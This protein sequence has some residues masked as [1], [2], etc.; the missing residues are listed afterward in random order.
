MSDLPAL[1]ESIEETEEEK[2]KISYLPSPFVAASLP[3]RDVKAPNFK[4]KFN[5]LE[6]YLTGSPKVP[7]GKY[8]RL[9]LSLLT[10]KAVI[11]PKVDEISFHYDTLSHLT[12]ELLLPRQR[13][14]DIREQ[15]VLFSLSSFQ[16]RE[17]KKQRI[18]KSLFDEYKDD[19]GFFTAVWN[20]HGNISF[21]KNL[22]WVD[23]EDEKTGKVQNT[24]GFTVTLSKEFVELC[25]NHSVPIDYTVYS[26]I[27][28]PLGKDLYAWIIYRNNILA[29]D[30][31]LF[32]PRKAIVAQFGT[33]GCE[34]DSKSE[35][36]TYISIVDKLTEIKN[37]YYPDLKIT[38]ES[39]NMGFTLR[40]SKTIIA[41][42][43][44]RYVLV[45]NF[46]SF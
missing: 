34:M 20:S 44:K 11:S 12:D 22:Q 19:D 33:G 28:S 37:K 29:E 2:H 40:K 18:Q 6:L 36:Q 35:S 39:S 3:L 38:F 9:V 1:F 46:I 25:K 31:E 32:V 13:G 27:S 26:Q 45:T 24:I 30:E 15:L 43:D 23:L 16:Y 17:K 8:A 4:R 7:F 14:K 41:P 10:T 21:M 42:N 5:N